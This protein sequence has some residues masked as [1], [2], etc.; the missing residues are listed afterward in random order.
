MDRPPILTNS[1]LPSPTSTTEGRRQDLHR[2]MALWSGFRRTVIHEFLRT[3]DRP[4]THNQLA[5]LQEDLDAWLEHY[6]FERPHQGYPN[7][8]KRP[9]DT[10]MPFAKSIWENPRLKIP[11]S[12]LPFGTLMEILK[13]VRRGWPRNRPQST[14]LKPN[15]KH[16][17]WK[18]F[19]GQGQ[20]A[21]APALGPPSP[22]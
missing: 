11:V 7:L 17:T 2:P 18:R 21:L 8:G 13:Q 4:K 9:A 20:V 19:R 10:V 14:L 22:Q 12:I 3:A 6:N 5:A 16:L 15:L 1:T